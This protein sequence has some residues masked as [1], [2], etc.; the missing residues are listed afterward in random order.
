M[1]VVLCAALVTWCCVFFTSA[2]TGTFNVAASTFYRTLDILLSTTATNTFTGAILC[3]IRRSFE[4]L[5]LGS[6]A[7]FGFTAYGSRLLQPNGLSSQLCTRNDSYHKLFIPSFVEH[8]IA[9]FVNE[10]FS[11]HVILRRSIRTMSL[12]K[13]FLS[14]SMDILMLFVVYIVHTLHVVCSSHATL[15]QSDVFPNFIS[16]YILRISQYWDKIDGTNF[17]TKLGRI[18]NQGKSNIFWDHG[19]IEPDQ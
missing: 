12:H 15:P 9:F 3:T 2:R 1:H 4:H 7:Q 16:Q 8:S 13:C 18:Y 6:S 10:H 14:I 11:A 17:T 19:Y 5:V